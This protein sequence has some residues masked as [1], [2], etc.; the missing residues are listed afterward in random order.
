MVGAVDILGISKLLEQEN[1]THNVSKQLFNVWKNTTDIIVTE[2][3][4]KKETLAMF[5]KSIKFGDSIY[6]FTN[7]NDDPKK[8]IKYLLLRINKLCVSLRFSKAEM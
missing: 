8:Q 3:E 1:G 6:F 4:K 2:S 7:P 5:E